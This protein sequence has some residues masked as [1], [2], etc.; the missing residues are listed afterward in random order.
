[1]IPQL[2]AIAETGIK[3]CFTACKGKLRSQLKHPHHCPSE[4]TMGGGEE[5]K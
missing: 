4:R 3:T 1:M 5:E 2:N